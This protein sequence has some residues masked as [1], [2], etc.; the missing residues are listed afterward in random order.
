MREAESLFRR[1]FGKPVPLSA[2]VDFALT[3]Y[4]E[5]ETQKK[6]SE[7][8]TDYVA[9][10][11]HEH[12][13]DMPSISQFARIGRDL[14][15]LDRFFPEA[16]VSDLSVEK[17]VSYFEHGR[18]A[19]K[20]YNNRRGIVSTFIKFAFLRGWIAEN[21]I[22]KVPQ[23]RIRRRRGVVKT[24]S[25]AQTRALMEYMENYEGGRWVPYFALCLFAGIRP[26]VPHGEITRLKSDAIDLEK[27]EIFVSAEVSKIREPRKVKIEPNL[28]A[29]LRAYPLD[30]FP[31]NIGN[32]YQR[33]AALGK[34]F[35]LTHDVMRHTYISM[36]VAKYRSIGEAAIQAGNSESIIRRHYLDLKPEVE[37]KEF[38]QIVP[39]SRGARAGTQVA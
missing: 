5:P 16:A 3:N 18:P 21:P 7:G 27:A 2:C 36:F 23:H 33:R 22:L 30:K 9:S 6:L 12:E 14:K 24:L 4:R 32:F 29:W 17:L 39:S 25:V 8:I 19:L 10:K 35:G 15:R 26:S 28:A 13:Q 37:A 20:T 34:Q 1:L 11:R 38:F 31:I